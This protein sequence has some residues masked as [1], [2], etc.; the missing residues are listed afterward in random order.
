M[1]PLLEGAR[2]RMARN[3]Y[4]EVTY[5]PNGDFMW[6]RM[7]RFQEPPGVTLAQEMLMGPDPSG[8][9]FIRKEVAQAHSTR[10]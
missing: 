7:K 3:R 4:S 2:E 1:L 6:V 5:E 10:Y 8:R 9:W